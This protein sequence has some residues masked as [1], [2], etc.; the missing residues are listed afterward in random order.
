MEKA[1]EIFEECLKECNKIDYVVR[2]GRS[3]LYKIPFKMFKI[4]K[5]TLPEYFT[6]TDWNISVFKSVDVEVMIAIIKD[7]FK[8]EKVNINIKLQE[9][10]KSSKYIIES[11]GKNTFQIA[12]VTD[13]EK[14]TIGKNDSECKPCTCKGIKY[15][16]ICDCFAQLNRALSSD[17]FTKKEKTTI[18]ARVLINLYKKGLFKDSSAHT[19]K[20]VKSLEDHLRI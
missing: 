4:L 1:F 8:K 19:K 13:V 5:E 2:G 14:S 16:S 3:Y 7:K 18:R 12:W 15:M 6:N 20:L 9:N 10:E 11:T 17:T